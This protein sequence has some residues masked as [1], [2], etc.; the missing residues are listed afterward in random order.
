M[1][2]QCLANR[3]IYDLVINLPLLFFIRFLAD[4]KKKGHTV[5][6]KILRFPAD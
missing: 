5:A 6:L 3:Y 2:V 1:P 4:A